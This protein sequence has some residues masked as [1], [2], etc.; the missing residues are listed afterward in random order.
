VPFL[1]ALALAALVW[2]TFGPTLTSGF[3]VYDDPVY[4]T[5]NEFVQGGLR[6][7]GI[8]WAFTTSHGA[9]WHPLTWLSHMLDVSLYGLDARGHHATSLLLHFANAVLVF[10]LLRSMAGATGAALLVAALFAV[11]PTRL[12]SVV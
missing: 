12:E 7:P 8:R 2:F 4:V 5:S 1:G 3:L 6:W 9:N 10:L 11:H